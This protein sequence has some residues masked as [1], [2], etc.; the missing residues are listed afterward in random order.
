MSDPANHLVMIQFPMSEYVKDPSSPLGWKTISH[1]A[2]KAKLGAM[3]DAPNLNP[4]AMDEGGEGGGSD[5]E[6]DV[7]V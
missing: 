5:A 6:P 7:D 3:P 1:D 4:D 2:N